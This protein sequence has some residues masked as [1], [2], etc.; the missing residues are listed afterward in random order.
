MGHLNIAKEQLEQLRERIDRNPVGMPASDSAYEILQLLFTDEE[1]RLGT[2]MPMVPASLNT[3]ARRLDMKPDELK[4][5]LDRM[6]DKGLV[7]DL[8]HPKR[9]GESMYMLAPPIVGFIEF[10]MMRRREDMDQPR[11]AELYDQYMRVE[12]E[13]RE[14][15]FSGQTQ[16]GRA[17]VHE[18]TIPEDN[19]VE[20]L[21]YEKASA[22][23]RDSG[24]GAL[25]VCYCRHKAEHL[26][27]ACDA[28]QEVCTILGPVVDGFV[29]HRLARKADVPELLD[30]LAQTRE[31]GLVHIG[32]NVQKRPVYICHC[33]SCCCGQLQAINRFGL[34]Q[35]VHTSNFLAVVAEE[36]CKGCGR[37]ARRCPVSAITLHQK[38]QT[39]KRMGKMNAKVDESI[40]LGCGVCIA[41]CNKD[42]LKMA[43]RQQR[44]LTPETTIERIV[45]MA[46]ERGKLHNFIADPAGGLTASTMNRVLKAVL[47]L[48]SA[49]RLSLEGSLGSRFFKSILSKAKKRDQV[50]KGM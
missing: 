41:A 8:P 2:L 38:P 18:T 6:A 5:K 49:R 40:C 17:L 14:Q 1:A 48:P 36:T 32:D 37:C 4:P 30:V 43:P 31:L 25:S 42:S 16:I 15:L 22:M 3:V 12:T 19:T 45:R 9:Q 44:V 11:L 33:C 35:A 27:K 29:N 26:G 46:A 21:D 34:K 28:P 50:P 23:I 7:M 13:F 20:V 47:K 39:G 10:S 24:G